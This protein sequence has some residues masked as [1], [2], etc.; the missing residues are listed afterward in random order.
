MTRSLRPFIALLLLAVLPGCVTHVPMSLTSGLRGASD[1]GIQLAAESNGAPF[2]LPTR[3]L[4]V[5]PSDGCVF[6]GGTD[7]G[8]EEVQ[9]ATFRSQNGGVGL[10]LTRWNDDAGVGFSTTIGAGVLGADLTLRPFGQ[11]YLT[12]S[13][14]FHGGSSVLVSQR[15]LDTGWAT[16]AVGTGYER[17]HYVYTFSPSRYTFEFVGPTRTRFVDVVGLR[18]VVAF[19]GIEQPRGTIKGALHLHA[20]YAPAHGQMLIRFGISLGVF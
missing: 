1:A 13:H 3:T 18:G 19:Q 2:A 20:G 7:C 16:I 15:V 6:G 11:T 9:R 17:K 12:A 8:G 10:H 14:S 4:I 5:P